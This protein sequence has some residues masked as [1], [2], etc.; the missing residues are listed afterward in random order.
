MTTNPVLAALNGWADSQRTAAAVD[1]AADAQLH[2]IDCAN[3]A[4]ESAED[5]L[6]ART[7]PHEEALGKLLGCDPIE[8]WYA[9]AALREK[10][11]STND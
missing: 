11:L 2:R 8:V 10:K 6:D 4:A 3:T 7:L 9:C 1:H 5:A